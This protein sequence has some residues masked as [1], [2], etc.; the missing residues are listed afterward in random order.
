M[1]TIINRGLGLAAGI[2][3]ATSLAAC[4]QVNAP[5]SAKDIASN[6]MFVSFQLYPK[7]LDPV[8]SYSLNETPYM[9]QT[10]EPLLHY[11]YLKRP[12]ELEGLTTEALPTVVLIDKAGKPL[13]D[14]APDSDVAFSTYTIHLRH[15]V[16]YQPHPALA[17]DASGHDLYLSLT[18]D[19]I[20]GKHSIWEF[21]LDKAATTT[22]EM[23]AD[24]YVYEIKRLASPYV[25]TPSPIYSLMAS[26]IVGL[27]E[28]S[29]TLRAEH[30][31]ELKALPPGTTYLPWHDLRNDPLEGARAIDKYTLEIRIKGRY[32]QFKHWLAQ[33][34]FVPIPWEADRFYAQKGMAEQT[35]SLN[36]WPIGT[37]P[38]MMTEQNPNHFVEARNPNY[39]GERY[40]SEGMP[41]DKEAGLLDDAGKPMPFI[42]KIVWSIE[43]EAEPRTQ[44]FMQ[45]YYDLPELDRLDDSFDLLKEQMDNTG[46]AQLIRDHG[47]RM[48]NAHDPI[49]WYIGFNWLDPVIGKGN[50]PEQEVRNRKLR[51]AISIATNW[52]EY[53]AVFFDFYG[54]ATVAMG[55]I[56]PALFGYRDGKEGIDPVTHVWKD[57]QAVRRPLEEAKKLLAEAG[58]P[59]GRDAKT[60]RPLVLTY[61]SREIGPTYQGRLSWQ[62]KQA[63]RLG[64]QLEAHPTDYNRFQDRIRQGGEQLF[65]WGWNADYPDPEDFLFLLTT[66][67]GVVKYDGDNQANY[68]NPQYDALY[69]RMKDLPDGPER[70]QVIDQMVGIIQQDAPWE[71]GEFPGS[72]RATQAWVSNVRPSS[73]VLD[74]VKYMRVDGAKRAEMLAQWN[75]P[76]LWPVILIALGVFA[77]F[78]PAWRFYQ[79][80]QL[81]NARGEVISRAPSRKQGESA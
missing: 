23:T 11:N 22:R 72:T 77:V 7:F 5:Y 28:L 21:P 34:F 42:D 46:R 45:G 20:R 52:E 13:P 53:A 26:Y 33:T 41:G 51:Q 30:D 1:P 37:G 59:D 73:V 35:L 25:A 54:P 64:I 43:K 79:R 56:P 16:R 4:N 38:Y 71:F 61:D 69:K 76:K 74:S 9:H 3:L 49:N 75:R 47:I 55:P 62:I 6:A 65:F 27:R 24:D 78:W 40:P 63:A 81:T 14:G 36:T 66:D 10:Y 8:S 17:K 57:G 32:P 18:P 15:G 29:D 58:Y 50:T 19:E 44:K 70:Q 60:G 67:Q 12:F 31:R 80:R 2:A 48:T 39:W 68:S